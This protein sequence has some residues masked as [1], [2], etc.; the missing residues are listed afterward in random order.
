MSFTSLED[1]AKV[2]RFLVAVQRELAD[3]TSVWVMSSG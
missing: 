1:P 3:H 2:S